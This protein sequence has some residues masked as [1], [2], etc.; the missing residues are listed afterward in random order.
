MTMDELA[1]HGGYTGIEIYNT[2]RDWENRTRFAEAYWDD[3]L[4]RR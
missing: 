3:P 1:A 2:G 4:R